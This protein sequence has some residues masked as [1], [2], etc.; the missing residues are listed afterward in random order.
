MLCLQ[1][2]PGHTI[3][4]GDPNSPSD[5]DNADSPGCIRIVNIGD[6]S[7]RL[8]IT[9]PA[10]VRIVRDDA[11]NKEPRNRKAGA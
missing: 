8:G 4:I 11:I 3:T 7:A 10:N 1:L 5:P 9:A 6:R 2:F